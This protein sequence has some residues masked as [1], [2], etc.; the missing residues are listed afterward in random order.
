MMPRMT[1]LIT[2]VV[3]V[4]IAILALSF[5]PPPA[6]A[7]SEPLPP[8]RDTAVELLITENIQTL[9]PEPSVLGGTYYVT[10]VWAEGGTGV[11]SYEDGHVAHT[12]DFTYTTDGNNTITS[13]VIRK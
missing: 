1:R 6:Q 5:M 7:P 2:I 11:V 3:L 12:A 8:G 13:F 9:S 10:E 4:L